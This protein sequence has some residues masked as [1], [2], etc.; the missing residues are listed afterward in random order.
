MIYGHRVLK[1]PQGKLKRLTKIEPKK[2]VKK[3]NTVCCI[4][5]YNTDCEAE[6]EKGKHTIGSSNINHWKQILKKKI[7]GKSE[8]K[9]A[10]I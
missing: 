10:Q 8:K 5:R 3:L 4:F 7:Q 1:T 2:I 9:K 6:L